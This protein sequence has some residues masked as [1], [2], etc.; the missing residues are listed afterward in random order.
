MKELAKEQEVN[1]G[2]AFVHRILDTAHD[3]QNNC[4]IH[5]DVTV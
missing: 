3:I 5:Q 4:H 2:N 1:N